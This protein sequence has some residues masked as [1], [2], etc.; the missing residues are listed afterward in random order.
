MSHRPDSDAEVD[1]QLHLIVDDG[2]EP[3]LRHDDEDG[4]GVLE[5]DLESE[6]AGAHGVEGGVAPGAVLVL[7]D[8]HAAPARRADDE[9][10]LK[11]A[12]DDQYRLREL[13]VLPKL[14]VVLVVVEALKGKPRLLDEGLGG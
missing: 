11:L 7:R 12:R 5:T 13:H 4:L 8:E 9:G 3:L 1:A 2:V 6:T 14:R 10:A